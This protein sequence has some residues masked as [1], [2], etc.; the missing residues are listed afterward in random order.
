MIKVQ[1]VIMLILVAIA[2]FTWSLLLEEKD[3]IKKILA[4]VFLVGLLI[5]I[6]VYLSLNMIKYRVARLEKK[7]FKR[8]FKQTLM[9]DY[10]D[11]DMDED[12]YSLI[13]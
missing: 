7:N 6:L 5:L 3:I 11:H 12:E 10:F 4:L 13:K 9:T 2:Y 1:H 8:S